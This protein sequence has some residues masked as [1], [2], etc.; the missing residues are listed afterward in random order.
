[1]RIGLIKIDGKKTITEIMDYLNV[2]KQTTT[3]EEDT[4]EI[5]E[6]NL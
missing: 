3:L 6:E 2:S 4:L 1:M 5:I